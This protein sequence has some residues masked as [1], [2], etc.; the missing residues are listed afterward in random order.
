MNSNTPPAAPSLTVEHD[1][2]CVRC[3][4][5]LRM[6]QH[7]GRCP[8]CGTPVVLTVELGSEFAKSRPPYVRRLS[9]ACWLLFLAR[10][11]PFAA[12]LGELLLGDSGWTPM[13][14]LPLAVLA[15]SLGLWL[16]AAREHPHLPP[17]LRWSSLGLHLASLAFFAC[18]LGMLSG[19]LSGFA[20][21]FSP[22]WSSRL[23]S[24]P[25]TVSWLFDDRLLM[26]SAIVCFGVYVLC[27]IMETRLMV[28]LARRLANAWLGEHAL[29]AGIGT[30]LSGIGYAAL[31]YWQPS[32]NGKTSLVVAATVVTFLLLFW[33]WMAVCSFTAAQG[34]GRAARQAEAR[35]LQSEAAANTP[36]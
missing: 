21:Q 16:L 10:T 5:N 14:L 3:G 18:L 12:V 6:L 35:W 4:Y 36:R 24:L 19:W 2:A 8:E 26:W 20:R 32:P 33:L 31:I 11:L 17:E 9:G 15:Y 30:F 28:R 13:V 1:L 23:Q 34:F 7:S 22:S 27:P 29:I 25:A